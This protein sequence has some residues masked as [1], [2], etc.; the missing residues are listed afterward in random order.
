VTLSGENF[1]TQNMEDL[2]SK[3]FTSVIMPL[4]KGRSDVRFWMPEFNEFGRLTPQ[5][6]AWVLKN[7]PTLYT[8][9]Y[10]YEHLGP[11]QAVKD[12]CM[13]WMRQI[14]LRPMEDDKVWMDYHFVV[15]NRS[16]SLQD[17][18][19]VGSIL[20]KLGIW[21]S[22]ADL[23]TMFRK[24]PFIFHIENGK[25]IKG[26]RPSPHGGDGGDL[27]NVRYVVAIPIDVLVKCISRP[28]DDIKGSRWYEFLQL[29]PRLISK[30]RSR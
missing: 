13:A 5:G 17:E 2:D 16:H 19:V 24:A 9:S 27:T 23:A 3:K 26:L 10:S 28:Y 7:R 20:Q 8:P 12:T 15:S 30:S 22:K 29:E 14:H 4:I 6:K 25:L 1:F 11:V 18:T 21:N